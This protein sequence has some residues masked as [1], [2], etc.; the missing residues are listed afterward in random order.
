MLIDS[1]K[2][3]WTVIPALLLLFSSGKTPQYNITIK[4]IFFLNYYHKN[5][6]YHHSYCHRR[7]ST[8][9]YYKRQPLISRFTVTLILYAFITYNLTYWLNL[10]CVHISEL[11]LQDESI[12]YRILLYLRGYF[13]VFALFDRL[14]L[15]WIRSYRTLL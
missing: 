1:T 12:W 9:I 2:T 13:T 14:R 10:N 5:S 3:S 4:I 6:N 15:L 7:L 11:S 8:Y